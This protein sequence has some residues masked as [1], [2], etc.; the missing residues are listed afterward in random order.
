MWQATFFALRAFPWLYS[1][2][3]NS[4]SWDGFSDKKLKVKRLQCQTHTAGGN[5]E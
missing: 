4:N 2:G 3:D 5:Y 1:C